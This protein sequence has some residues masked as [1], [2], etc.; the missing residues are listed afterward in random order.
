MRTYADYTI[1]R[2]DKDDR[3]FMLPAWTHLKAGDLL[4][5]DGT[6]YNVIADAINLN[7]ESEE[8]RF[9]EILYGKTHLADAYMKRTQCD[10]SDYQE[11]KKEEGGDEE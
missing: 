6:V 4:I 5:F 9:L 3:L 11:D 2:H 10:Y 7:R 8:V 1:G